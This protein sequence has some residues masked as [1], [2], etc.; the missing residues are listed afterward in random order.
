[1]NE[2]STTAP[3]RPASVAALHR[4]HLGF[5]ASIDR[6]VSWGRQPRTKLHRMNDAQAS[7]RDS[8][9]SGCER[10]LHSARRGMQTS[11]VINAA[12]PA[13]LRTPGWSRERIRRAYSERPGKK[14]TTSCAALSRFVRNPT[15]E[16]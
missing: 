3:A 2:W 11:E 1:M 5:K 7:V 15:A 8:N 6:C 10:P 13:D 14:V 4:A 9:Q 16:Q 12:V